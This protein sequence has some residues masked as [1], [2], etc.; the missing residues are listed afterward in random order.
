MVLSNGITTIFCTVESDSR[1]ICI[2]II[3]RHPIRSPPLH[4]AP[5]LWPVMMGKR[6]D[7]MQ[8]EWHHVIDH[9]FTRIHHHLA[10]RL[11]KIR[12]I[13]ES[14]TKDRKSTRLNSSHVKISYA[15]FCLKKKR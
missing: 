8:S 12:R 14:L 1:G 4:V 6:E 2:M 13:C 3:P 11:H 9:R 10:N 5:R 7:M 15:V